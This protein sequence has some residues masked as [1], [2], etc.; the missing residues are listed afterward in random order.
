MQGQWPL[1]LDLYILIHLSHT[2]NQLKEDICQRVPSDIDSLRAEPSH[3]VNLNEAAYIPSGGTE[4]HP[5]VSESDR[6][7]TYTGLDDYDTLFEARHGRGALDHMPRT[8]GEVIVTSSRGMTPTT[9][10]TGV[11]ENPMVRTRPIPDNGL[12]SNNQKECVSASADPSMMG[13]RVVSPISSGPIM[14]EGAAIFTDMTETMLS[15]LD[16][17]MAS[18]SEAQKPEGSLTDNVLTTGQLIGSN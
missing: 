5:V 2:F 10:S 18:S 4:Y 6:L 8:S 9:L 12:P 7:S 1:V 3:S 16:Q 13:H 15:A 17:Q 11:I 14:G